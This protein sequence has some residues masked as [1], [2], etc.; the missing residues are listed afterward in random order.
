MTYWSQA[1]QDE[2]VANVLNFK[3]NGYFLDIGSNNAQ[4]QSN[5]YFFESELGW[6]GACIE[7]SPDHNHSYAIRTCQFLNQDAT[8]VDYEALFVENGYPSHMDYLSL[9]ID[10]NSTAAL[11]KLPLDTYRFRVITIEHDQYRVGASYKE[12]QRTILRSVGYTLLFPEVLVPLGCGMGPD[13]PFED[14]WVDASSFNMS[15]LGQLGAARMYPDHIVDMI[16]K[17]RDTYTI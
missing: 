15:K 16:K 13:L 12:E 6:K 10:E 11:L 4:Q 5:S 8:K 3:R 9:D 2:F 14:W 1:W 7:M 17:T